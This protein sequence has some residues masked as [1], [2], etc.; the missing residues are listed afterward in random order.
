MSRP[1]DPRQLTELVTEFARP[2]ILAELAILACCL[3]AAWIVVRLIRGR[4]RPVGPTGAR[5][6]HDP[7][8]KVG[9]D[10]MSPSAELGE[11]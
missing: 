2:G 1:F 11:P 8:R 5:T 4:S 9:R 3:V 7:P 6:R 10:R